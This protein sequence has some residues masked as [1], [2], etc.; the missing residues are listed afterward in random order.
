[1]TTQT[2]QPTNG[3][4]LDAKRL[5]EV[6][7]YNPDTGAFTWLLSTSNRVK[8]GDIAGRIANGYRG[9]RI[10]GVLHYAHRLAVLYVTGEW[11]ESVVDHRDGRR[12]N[13][14]W[15]N[16]RS[17]T[18]TVNTQNI[19]TAHRGSATG[20]LG[21]SRHRKKFDASIHVN[22]KRVRLGRYAT[23]QMAGDVY[24]KAKQQLHPGNTL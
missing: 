21:V 11:P 6:L 10:D 7:H 19:R 2:K 12:A 13:N 3:L 24:I 22:G 8:I 20:L 18:Q 15:T 14:V 16:L 1:M 5:R 17:C 23:A 9:I 4:D